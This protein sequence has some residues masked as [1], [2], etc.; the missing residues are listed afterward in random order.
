MISILLQIIIPIT[1]IQSIIKNM[2]SVIDKQFGYKICIVI[3]FP[4]DA[5]TSRYSRIS[6]IMPSKKDSFY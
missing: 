1:I 2:S 6:S 3:S 4:E 5:I